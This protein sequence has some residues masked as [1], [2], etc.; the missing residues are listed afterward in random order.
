MNKIHHRIRLLSLLSIFF[1]Y[2]IIT[3]EN[4][5]EM[6]LW[7]MITIVFIIS[8]IIMLVVFKGWKE[9]TT[10]QEEMMRNMR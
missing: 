1:V 2:K 7:F 5:E 4:D 8:I 9:E 3:A 10:R 6:S